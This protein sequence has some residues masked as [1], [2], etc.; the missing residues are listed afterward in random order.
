MY[1]D[2]DDELD[3]YIY[4]NLIYIS[5]TQFLHK[6]TRRWEAFMGGLSYA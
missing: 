6:P 5:P 3:N 4:G 2:V 1:R